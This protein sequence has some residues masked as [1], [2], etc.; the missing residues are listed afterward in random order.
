MALAAAL[1]G[2]SGEILD[3]VVPIEA[4]QGLSWLY[5]GGPEGA[6][7]VL[8]TVAGSM[9]TVAGVTFSVTMVALAL[10]SSQFGPRIL[11]NFMRDRGN[12]FVLGTFIAT[13]LYCLFVLRTVRGVEESQ[14]VPH[15]SVTIAF[16][17]AI[18][19]VAVLIYFIDHMATAIQAPNVVDRVRRAFLYG[20][21][22]TDIQNV[23]W[24]R[25]STRSASMAAPRPMSWP[26]F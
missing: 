19:S 12:Q 21:T 18:A 20:D 22:G 24:T 16:V 1:L 9:I 13:F 15:I 2:V 17:L 5:H 26:T 7:A 8:S 25:P 10:A 3:R 6:R 14:F 4:V 11:K 23:S